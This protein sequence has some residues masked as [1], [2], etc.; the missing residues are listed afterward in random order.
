MKIKSYLKFACRFILLNRLKKYGKVTN[1]FESFSSNLQDF[2]VA[3]LFN[4]KEKGC[5]VEIGSQDPIKNSNTCALEKNYL[6][7]GLSFELDQQYV[8]F[9]NWS[10]K[11][12]CIQGDA[13]KQN[14]LKIFDENK[15]P[16]QIDYLQIDIDPPIASLTALKALPHSQYRFTFITFEHDAY[17]VGND[18][19][20]Q[21]RKV[22]FDLGYVIL[23][24]NVMSEDKIFEDWWVDP[25]NVDLPR[26]VSLPIIE[27]AD[28]QD[29]IKVLN[30]SLKVKKTTI[31]VN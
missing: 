27:N 1:G 16:N 18:I 24:K 4:F 19:A 6:W 15:I 12:I 10:R 28:Y 9:F 17:A 21:Q 5:Y 3:K 30:E 13:T 8:D 23:A 29:V 22:L 20:D 2:A 26:Y 31:T 11:N 25:L 14:Y 7:F